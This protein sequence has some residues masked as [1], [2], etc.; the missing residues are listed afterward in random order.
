MRGRRF[1]GKRRGQVWPVSWAIDLMFEKSWW[2]YRKGDSR[3]DI[4]SG[5]GL[6]GA[7]ILKTVSEWV[8]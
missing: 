2:H 6:W 4:T 3:Y 5:L 8:E 7:K 1:I